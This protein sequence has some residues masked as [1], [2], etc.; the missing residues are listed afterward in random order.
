MV[1]PL[2][3]ELAERQTVAL[4]RIADLLDQLVSEVAGGLA[5]LADS[6]DAIEVKEND[7]N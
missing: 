1:T 7:E 2:E 3:Q 4:E 5:V 6:V